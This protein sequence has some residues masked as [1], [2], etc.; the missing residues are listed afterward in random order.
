[1]VIAPWMAEMSWGGIPFTDA[2][3]V[4]VFLGPM[5]GGAALLTREFV[6]RTRRGWPA[7]LLLA[8]AFGVFQAGVVDQSLFNPSYGRYDFQHPVHIDGIDISLYY[9]VN[10]VA[11]HVVVSITLPITLAEAWSAARMSSTPAG[12]DSM[13]APT[14]NQPRQVGRSS[15]GVMELELMRHPMR[16]SRSGL[17]GYAGFSSPGSNV[18]NSADSGPSVTLR[19]K[20]SD[21]LTPRPGGRRRME[22]SDMTLTADPAQANYDN[23]PTESPLGAPLDWK[24]LKGAKSEWGVRP[25]I[26]PRGL[27]M[28]DIATGSV[29]PMSPRRRTVRS[30]WLF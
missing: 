28:L 3:L 9:L 1:M 19:R 16:E 8:A 22:D 7:I 13:N 21:C 29:I 2:L 4:V 20:A 17:R 18:P 12:M 14:C 23:L 30:K 15:A 27:T 11:G 24:W 10:F 5:Y 26:G 25:K 6:R